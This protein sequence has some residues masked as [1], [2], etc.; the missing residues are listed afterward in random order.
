MEMKAVVSATVQVLILG[1]L[2][3]GEERKIKRGKRV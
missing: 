2:E 1:E 3:V